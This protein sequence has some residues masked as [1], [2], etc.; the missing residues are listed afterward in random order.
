MG[1]G[2]GNQTTIPADYPPPDYEAP[3]LR[4]TNVENNDKKGSNI[5][6]L[7]NNFV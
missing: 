3:G 2:D 5:V 7:K 1:T 4:T 6:I